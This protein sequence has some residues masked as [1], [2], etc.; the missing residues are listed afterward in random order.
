MPTDY[1]RLRESM[2]PR[3]PAFWAI[4][5]LGDLARDWLVT[6]NIRGKAAYRVEN[7]ILRAVTA[8][9]RAAE[10]RSAHAHLERTRRSL[11]DCEQALL[12]LEHQLP[13]QIIYAAVCRI[14]RI[15]ASLDELE[16]RPVADWPRIE[17]PPERAI[18]VRAA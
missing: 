17:L 16:R 13:A 4:V 11:H 6:S 3:A 5:E 14:D 10:A 15:L 9:N 8:I 18:A 7:T 1:K 2:S 12:A